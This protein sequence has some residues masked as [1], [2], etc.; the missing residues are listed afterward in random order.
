MSRNP[1][2]FGAAFVTALFAANVAAL[3]ITATSGSDF[4]IYFDSI[5]GEPLASIDGL[6]AKVRFYNF[7]FAANGSNTDA[8]FSFDIFNTS[9][10]PVLTSRVS[11]LGFNTTPNVDANSTTD[12]IS[13][14]FDSI[15]YGGNVPNQGQMEFCF[16]D[17]N[18]AGGG[19][20]G[21]AIGGSSLNNSATL[22][23][24]GTLS[25]IRFDKFTDR[26]QSVSCIT[27]YTGNCPSSASGAGT[28]TPPTRVPE[29]GT[30]SL[31]AAGLIALGLIRRRVSA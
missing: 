19:S 8:M 28:D 2:R 30:L 6:S 5:G 23:F 27:G 13:G 11:G 17:V 7:S 31:F 10:S 29:P 24:L 20:A 22:T 4:T 16:S 14:I 1:I 21:V 3:P 18:C 25:S 15:T 12:T 9:T 26:Y